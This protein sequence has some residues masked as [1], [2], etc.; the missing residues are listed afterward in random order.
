[1]GLGIL[2]VT[3]ATQKAHT[4]SGEKKNHLFVVFFVSDV[5]FFE[6]LPET[7]CVCSFA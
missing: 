3:L 1:M 5:F 4:R 6:W 7:A 2:M